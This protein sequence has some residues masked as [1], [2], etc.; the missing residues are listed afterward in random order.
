MPGLSKKEKAE[1][2]FFIDPRTGRRT[3]N[4]LCGRCVHDCKQSYK[5]DIL[6]CPRYQSKRGKQGKAKKG[7]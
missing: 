7:K 1:W 2:D 6:S 5:A 3:Y 4:E